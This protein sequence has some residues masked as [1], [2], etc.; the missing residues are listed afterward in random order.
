MVNKSGRTGRDGEHRAAQI[1]RRSG[2]T[3]AERR[4]DRKP[5]EDIDGLPVPLEVKRHKQ[6]QYAA[7]TKKVRDRHSDG[8]WALMI[9]PRDRRSKDSIPEAITFPAE[10]GADLLYFAY[11]NGFFDAD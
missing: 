6:V 4:L 3:D 1:M 2:F 8:Y 7:W 5:S 10:L 11:E 9:L